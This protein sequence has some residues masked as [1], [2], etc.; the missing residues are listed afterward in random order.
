MFAW[1]K[2][3]NFTMKKVSL[4][5]KFCIKI[6]ENNSFFFKIRY[7]LKL[8]RCS[9]DN[10]IKL[11]TCILFSKGNTHNYFKNMSYILKIYLKVTKNCKFSNVFLIG[12]KMCQQLWPMK[13]HNSVIMLILLWAKTADIVPYSMNYWK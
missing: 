12:R 13:S 1:E 4:L 10:V 6:Q 5:K 7:A 3:A 9:Y 8:K 2:V 11:C